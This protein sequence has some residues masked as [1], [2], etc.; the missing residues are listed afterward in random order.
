MN[1]EPT[2]I[3]PRVNK[4]PAARPGKKRWPRANRPNGKTQ[5]VNNVSQITPR[6]AGRSCS[7]SC[8]VN[9]PMY[10]V[11]PQE[12]IVKLPRAGIRELTICQGNGR[13]VLAGGI[14]E[15]VANPGL[16]ENILG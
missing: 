3:P 16:G 5:P 2:T 12:V 10:P 8:A 9:L 6:T 15:S 14:A 7:R 11:T 4:L 13:G 1:S